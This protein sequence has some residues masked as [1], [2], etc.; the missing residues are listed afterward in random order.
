[1]SKKEEYFHRYGEV[2]YNETMGYSIESTDDDGEFIILYDEDLLEEETKEQIVQNKIDILTEHF[3][4]PGW[5]LPTVMKHE[6]ECL[7][8]LR[9]HFEPRKDEPIPYY[10]ISLV[11][12][13][14]CYTSR[15]NPL[16]KIIISQM[17]RRMWRAGLI[18]R[19]TRGRSRRGK[20][21]AT[22]DAGRGNWWG[23]HYILWPRG[24]ISE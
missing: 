22:M 14:C 8:A 19:F 12:Y 13:D 5:E 3:P 1:M 15:G 4:D 6:L 24:E 20:N 18:R 7:D 23:V 17:L 2:P 10:D 9:A 11:M 21:K 16:H